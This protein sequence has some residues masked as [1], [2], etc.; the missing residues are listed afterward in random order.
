V[1]KIAKFK[2]KSVEV[3]VVKRIQIVT[4][5]IALN[6]P[7]PKMVRSKGKL[8]PMVNAFEM[9]NV[10]RIVVRARVANKKIDFDKNRL[11]KL[12]FLS[13]D[14]KNNFGNFNRTLIH[15]KNILIT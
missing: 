13:Y 4:P 10:N 11:S 7:V 12:F 6:P 2:A 9:V 8:V 3:D 1:L 15:H 14:I 5:I